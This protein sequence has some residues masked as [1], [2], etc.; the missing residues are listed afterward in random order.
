MLKVA[1]L[2]IRYYEDFGIEP[3]LEIQRKN[4]EKTFYKDEAKN[5]F[6]KLIGGNTKN[7][8]E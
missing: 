2:T 1:E 6:I 8:L 5:L 7:E 3:I 4:F